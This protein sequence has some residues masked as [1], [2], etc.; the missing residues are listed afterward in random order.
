ML[1]A[2]DY[3]DASSLEMEENQW[4]DREDLPLNVEALAEAV[5]WVERED[6][7]TDGTSAWIQNQWV[8]PSYDLIDGCVPDPDKHK[9]LCGTAY[10]VAGHVTAIYAGERFNHRDPHVRLDSGELVHVSDF[11]A[12]VLGI[13][14]ADADTLFSGDNTAETIRAIAENIAGQELPR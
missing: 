7:K 5:R 1:D 10:C 13:N 14:L 6:A 3:L 2:R 9:N 8:T 12:H 4:A 11:A